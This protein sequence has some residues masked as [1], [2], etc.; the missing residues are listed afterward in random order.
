MKNKN[1]NTN[2]Y[3]SNIMAL[4]VK[5]VERI[6]WQ[7]VPLLVYPLIGMIFLI[8]LLHLILHKLMGEKESIQQIFQISL[9]IRDIIKEECPGSAIYMNFINIFP[10]GIIGAYIAQE[11]S[12]ADRLTQSS[13][14][15]RIV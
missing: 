6:E 4:N 3:T 15:F 7:Q 9:T 11:V 5:A 13:H 2:H 12:R 1:F 8:K 14:F 10:D